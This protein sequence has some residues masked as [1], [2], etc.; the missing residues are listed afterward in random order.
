MWNKSADGK[1]SADDDISELC[2]AES[3][4]P[5]AMEDSSAGKIKRQASAFKIMLAVGVVVFIIFVFSGG[6]ASKAQTR[7]FLPPVDAVNNLNIDPAEY[8]K[9]VE[10]TNQETKMKVEMSEYVA[11]VEH[12]HHQMKET[13]SDAHRDE[14]VKKVA[15]KSIQDLAFNSGPKKS[16]EQLGRMQKELQ[17]ASRL[18]TQKREHQQTEMANLMAS[19]TGLEPDKEL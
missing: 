1:N 6:Q 2:R 4:T 13:S 5:R 18:Q 14:A 8:A 19:I 7:P 12:A 10:V 11:K 16:P 9:S 15:M 3:G 17:E